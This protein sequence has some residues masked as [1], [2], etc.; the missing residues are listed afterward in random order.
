L[1]KN[2]GGFAP[3][4]ASNEVFDILGAAD[5]RRFLDIKT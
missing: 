1:F 2:T 3:A 4:P 5:E